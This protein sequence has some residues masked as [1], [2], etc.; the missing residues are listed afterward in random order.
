MAAFMHSFKGSIDLSLTF[1]YALRLYQVHSAN[2]SWSPNQDSKAA[3]SVKTTLPGL[4]RR[5][6]ILLPRSGPCP[7][8]VYVE[9]VPEAIV[10]GENTLLAVPGLHIWPWGDTQVTLLNPVLQ[11]RHVPPLA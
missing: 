7:A 4:Q 9:L 8:R 1:S 11:R 3:P 2:L 5:I 6:P 10:V